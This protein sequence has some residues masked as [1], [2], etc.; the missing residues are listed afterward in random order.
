MTNTT[1]HSD[2]H[3][4]RTAGGTETPGHGHGH[5][6]APGSPGGETRSSRGCWGSGGQLGWRDPRGAA[7]PASGTWR[8]LRL[9]EGLHATAWLPQ[10]GI[11][12]EGTI[13]WQAQL[14]GSSGRLQGESCTHSSAQPGTSVSPALKMF[15]IPNKAERLKD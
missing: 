8:G 7:A 4:T 5:T 1:R 9:H 11:P 15:I 3:G 14:Q 2:K 12:G 10:W 13:P 6:E